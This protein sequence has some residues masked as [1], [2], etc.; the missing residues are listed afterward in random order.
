M[1]LQREIAAR[2]AEKDREMGVPFLS[3]VLVEE[4]GEF[5]EAVRKGDR[6]HAGNEIADV[7]FMCYALAA[8][9][10]VDLDRAIRA[11]FLERSFEEATKTWDDVTWKS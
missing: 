3:M 10:D 11:K 2:Y 4:L 5:A 1:T 8:Q 6:A 7:A 9:L